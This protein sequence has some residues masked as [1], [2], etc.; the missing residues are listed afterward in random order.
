M[1]KNT[2]LR[3]DP[4][5]IVPSGD[6]FSTR[7]IVSRELPGKLTAKK[8]LRRR[9]RA[10]SLQR[11]KEGRS[12]VLPIGVAVE[13]ALQK[14]PEQAM[15]QLE[16][17]TRQSN[18]KHE[19]TDV[20]KLRLIYSHPEAKAEFFRTLARYTSE[21]TYEGR[22]SSHDFTVRRY[23]GGRKFSMADVGCSHGITTEETVARL[24]NAT[25]I[26]YDSFFPLGFSR[27]GKKAAY[28]EHDIL[29]GQLPRKFD[30]IRFVNVNPHLTTKG[31]EIARRN[32]AASLNENGLLV[33]NDYEKEEW[34]RAKIT[35]LY[36]KKGKRLVFLEKFRD[37]EEG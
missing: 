10:V 13:N 22:L 31:K 30:C 37:P 6:W 35:R 18:M 16:F 23:F 28:A 36:R 12:R 1:R 24:P 21:K 11:S 3:F 20:E 14:V 7:W 34:G 33:S 15:Q 2:A 32:L 5:R 26:G 19:L 25:V 4:R 29:L 27:K 17:E 9:M 8:H